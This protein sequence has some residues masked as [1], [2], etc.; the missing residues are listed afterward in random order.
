M[1]TERNV[2]Q[3]RHD[4]DTGKTGEKVDFPDPAVAP[5]GTDA[6]AGGHPPQP[7]E[8]RVELETAP[9]INNPR[10]G[11]P[12]LLIYLSLAGCVGAVALALIATSP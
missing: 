4:I 8:I 2:D 10:R 7:S 1:V 5:L 6:E 9:R 3:I 11:D 12:G